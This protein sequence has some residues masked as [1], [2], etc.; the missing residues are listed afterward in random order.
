[1]LPNSDYET[2]QEVRLKKKQAFMAGIFLASLSAA[3]TIN[4]SARSDLIQQKNV[5]A[6]LSGMFGF[7]S[8][9]A[10]RRSF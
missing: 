3:L 9:E 7:A 2:L 6:L 1:M 8:I 10:F 4:I 5:A